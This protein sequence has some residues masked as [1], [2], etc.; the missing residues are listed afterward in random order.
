MTELCITIQHPTGLHAR[1]LAQ[2]VKTAKM[3]NATIEVYNLTSG[4]GP[5]NGFSPLN[6][7]LLSI[8]QGHEIK[9]VTSGP[10]ENE[11][12]EALSVLIN[13]NFGEK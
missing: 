13:S 6:L 1:P 7:M 9:I 3:F 10:Q 2:F 5:A 12:M 11:A 8:Q 4:K